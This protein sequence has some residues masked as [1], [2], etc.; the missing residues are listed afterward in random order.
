LT[1]VPDNSVAV[2]VPATIKQRKVVDA[3]QYS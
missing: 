2:G 3:G 1:D